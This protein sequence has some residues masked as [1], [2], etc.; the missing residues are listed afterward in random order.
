MLLP[1]RNNP[2]RGA[3][4]AWL[5]SHEIC[6][7][8]VGEFSDSALLKTFGRGGLGLFP[9]PAAMHADILTQFQAHP[10]GPLQGVS[11]SWYAIS[12][13][14]RVPHPA[15]QIIEN[16]GGQRLIS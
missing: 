3:I 7:E 2:L 13:H 5:E 15:I 9:A 6:P 14:K 1:A 12:T 16:L 11:E 8:I 10:L 4:D